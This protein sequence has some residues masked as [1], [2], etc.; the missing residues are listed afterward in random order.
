MEEQELLQKMVDALA[1][2]NGSAGARS[3]AKMVTQAGIM[4]RTHLYQM[5]GGLTDN[6][7]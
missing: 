5:P 1:V 7:P 4:L 6:I 2:S 3:I